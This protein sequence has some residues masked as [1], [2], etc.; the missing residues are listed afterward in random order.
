MTK[1][2]FEYYEFERLLRDLLRPEAGEVQR[3]AA[4]WAEWLHTRTTPDQFQRLIEAREKRFAVAFANYRSSWDTPQVEPEGYTLCVH[5]EHCCGDHGC[6]YGDNEC[7]V[8]NGR[9]PQSFFC[10]DCR[11]GSDF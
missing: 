9:K 11:E 10:E 6:K 5:T 1:K 7:P 3:T 4:E 2:V 8:V